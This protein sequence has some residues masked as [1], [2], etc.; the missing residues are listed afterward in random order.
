[1]RRG[2]ISKQQEIQTLQWAFDQRLKQGLSFNQI[3][4]ELGEIASESGLFLFGAR[5]IQKR[6]AAWVDAGQPDIK[7]FVHSAK[8]R[9]RGI[10][11]QVDNPVDAEIDQRVEAICRRV[12]GEMLQQSGSV[13]RDTPPAPTARRG[14]RGRKENRE[15]RRYTIGIDVALADLFD[16][17]LEETGLSSGKLMDRILW[18]RYNKPRLSYE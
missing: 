7:E 2:P 14:E 9:G 1:M 16:K 17:E 8:P 6:F 10:I 12:V 15:Y 13:E 18:L 4:S 3:A 11:V 5:A